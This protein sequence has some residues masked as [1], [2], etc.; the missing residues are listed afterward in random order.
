ML[1]R[2]LD[3]NKWQDY[4]IKIIPKYALKLYNIQI[5]YI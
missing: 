1:N 3:Y 2:Y 5:Y 4:I